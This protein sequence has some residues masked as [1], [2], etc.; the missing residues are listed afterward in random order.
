MVLS[1]GN[2]YANKEKKYLDSLAKMSSFLSKL[3]FKSDYTNEMKH[4]Y[5][6]LEALIQ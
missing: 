6:A 5:E 3:F 4:V 2:S 1:N